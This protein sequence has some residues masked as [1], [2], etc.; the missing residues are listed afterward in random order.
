M[1]VLIHSTSVSIN[2]VL[3]HI[4]RSLQENCDQILIFFLLLIH[5]T[6]CCVLHIFMYVCMYVHIYR[7]YLAACENST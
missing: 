6:L 5:T 2:F 7:T 3:S 4:R 1:S